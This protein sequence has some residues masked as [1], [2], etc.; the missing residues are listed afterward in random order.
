MFC[1]KKIIYFLFYF[2]KIYFLF[3]IFLKIFPETAEA[4]ETARLCETAE[5][6]VKGY[7]RFCRFLL[8]TSFFY[9]CKLFVRKL[10]TF[11]LLINKCK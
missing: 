3:F 6:V 9:V 4:V 11:L 5:A 2:F 8:L 7:M 1:N 10:L